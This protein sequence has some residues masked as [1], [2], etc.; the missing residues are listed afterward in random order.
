MYQYTEE[1]PIDRVLYDV[2]LD[3]ETRM[4]LR[5]HVRALVLLEVSGGNVWDN[6]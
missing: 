6:T 3:A 2:T 1:V 4:D 5:S